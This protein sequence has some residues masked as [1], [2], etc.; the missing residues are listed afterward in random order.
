MIAGSSTSVARWVQYRF[1]GAM[2]PPK[3]AGDEVSAY[4]Q[5]EGKYSIDNLAEHLQ[6]T[7]SVLV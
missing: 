1:D 3:C 2:E 6:L 5:T 7:L 4:D